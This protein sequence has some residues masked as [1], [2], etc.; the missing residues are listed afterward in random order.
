MQAFISEKN[1]NDLDINF[2]LNRLQVVTPYGEEVKSKLKPYK[3]DTFPELLAQLDIL[4]TMM[5]R[6]ENKRHEVLAIKGLMKDIKSLRGT[7]ERLSAGE[8]LSVTELHEIK[9]LA[10][11]LERV[12]EA[13]E[14]IHWSKTV[15]V[16]ELKS[17]QPILDLLDPEESGVS[18]FHIYSIYSDKLKSIRDEMASVQKQMKSHLQQ[19]IESL[20]KKGI[21]ATATGEVRIR[22][23]DHEKLEK[24][25]HNSLLYYRTDI[26][27]Y[28]LF[29]VKAD[30]NLQHLWDQLKLEEEEEEWRVRENLCKSLKQCLDL[31]KYNVQSVGEV[32]LL[33]SKAQF[34]K[35]FHCVRPHFQEAQRIDIQGGR[36]LKIASQ[37]EREGKK[38][39]T[40]DIQLNQEV[41]VIT[42]AN[43]GGKTVSLKTMGHMVA[44]AHYG[45]YVPAEKMSLYPL[46]FVFISVGDDQSVDMGLSTF[47]AE[48][49]AI[50][51]A[52]KREKEKGLVLIDELARGTNPQEGQ[53]ISK[54][55]LEYL[56]KTP[57]QT[58]LTTHYD[59]LTQ[60][61]DI[62]HFQVKGLAHLDIEAMKDEIKQRGMD[63]LHEHMDYKLVKVSG[64]IGIPKEAIRI[65]E[66]MGLSPEI[67][68]RAKEILGGSNES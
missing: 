39:T 44:L 38:L 30:E 35:A 48:I 63:L 27:M 5:E 8:V 6:F 7:F 9:H 17:S 19:A 43:M 56:K 55:L 59:G 41:S 62:G 3:R 65:A 37:L 36:H 29:K 28:S 53:A 31:L 34:A 51:E 16:Y 26:P 60:G 4:E 13:M 24:A 42:G 1:Q 67:I 33:I 45:L 66:I 15:S 10:L 47:G 58:V 68:E 23:S 32:D 52:L 22:Q 18:T 57:W 11:T 54:A 20:E 25:K 49:V 12:R 40:L 14:K 2:V 46:D 64:E 21:Q 61:K 50:G